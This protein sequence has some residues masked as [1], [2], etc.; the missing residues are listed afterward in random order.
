MKPPLLSVADKRPHRPTHEGYICVD[1]ETGPTLIHTF[2]TPSL[3]ATILFLMQ[4]A[5]RMVALDTLQ[6][7]I[8]MDIT[9]L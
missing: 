6:Y 3:P 8:V 2:L 1:G 9:A 5:E 7:P 4:R